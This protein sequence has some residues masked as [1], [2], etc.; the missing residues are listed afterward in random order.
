MS[1]NVRSAISRHTWNIGEF[2]D[3]VGGGQVATPFDSDA[4]D[5]CATLSRA[6]M[7]SPDLQRHPEVVALGYWLRPASVERMRRALI[8]AEGPTTLLVP[9]GCVF[10]VTPANVDTMFVYSWILSM[11]TGNI[12]VVR[13]SERAGGLTKPLLG[14]IAAL[15]A[16]PR[17]RSVASRSHLVHTSHDD[18]ISRR[19]SSI[20]DVRVLWGGDSTVEHFRTFPLPP[21]GRDVTFP[22]RH[23]LAVFDASAV[24]ASSPSDLADLAGH[25]FNDAFWFDQGGCSSPRL[26]VWAAEADTD[27]ERSRRLFRAALNGVISSRAYTSETGQVLAKLAL[28][29]RAAAAVDGVQVNTS[30]NEATWVELPTLDGYSR[31]NCG[32]GLFFEYVS[33]DLEDD[34][35]RFVGPQD[36]TAVCFGLDRETVRRIARSLNGRGVDRWV[37]AGTALKFGTEWDGYDLVREFVKLVV[38]DV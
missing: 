3:L 27:I 30:S 20:A 7:E 29:L 10:H 2:T 19:L 34:L 38:I 25:F 5:F 28:A 17:H 36:Q 22:N 31:E 9:R 33:R 15:L 24:A 1:V 8:D 12:S 18:E 37:R 32:G 14:I 35:G 16:D 21:R 26:I 4:V 11:L 13:V 6:L 23:S